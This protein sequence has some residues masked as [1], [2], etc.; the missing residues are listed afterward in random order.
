MFDEYNGPRGALQ[1][2]AAGLDDWSRRV[3]IAALGEQTA[4]IVGTLFDDFF[5]GELRNVFVSE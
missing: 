1:L 3:L 4:I 2:V 5:E